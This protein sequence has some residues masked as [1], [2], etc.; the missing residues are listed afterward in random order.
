MSF[1]FFFLT[2]PSTGSAKPCAAFSTRP[3]NG[4]GES[5]LDRHRCRHNV[6]VFR[7]DG[8]RNQSP[9]RCC[10]TPRSIQSYVNGRF[11]PTRSL[12]E[13]AILQ[14]HVR[15][16]IPAP[17]AMT[18]SYSINSRQAQ[19]FIPPTELAGADSPVRR[20]RSQPALEVSTTVRARGSLRADESR[21]RNTRSMK[22]IEI[23]NASPGN[24]Y[25]RE[26]VPKCSH[27]APH[28][29]HV[30]ESD[31]RFEFHVSHSQPHRSTLRAGTQN[32]RPTSKSGERSSSSEKARASRA[33]PPRDV[34]TRC[35]TTSR[36][37]G[38]HPQLAPASGTAT[39]T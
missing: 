25:I 14:Q 2:I 24:R 23:L 35:L 17:E 15:V 12:I 10:S 19:A 30:R 20:H 11:S 1:A 34:R 8:P 36:I 38:R 31:F 27:G 9:R 21:V 13:L 16:R 22:A 18:L 6:P 26:S 39:S 7:I 33:T 4:F 5:H 29:R 32:A 28:H 3:S 37:S